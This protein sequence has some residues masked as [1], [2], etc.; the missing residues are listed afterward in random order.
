[1][2]FGRFGLF[3][4]CMANW[5]CLGLIGF[6][7]T[8]VFWWG[9]KTQGALS[10]DA[11]VIISGRVVRAPPSGMVSVAACKDVGMDVTSAE[12]QT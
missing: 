2:S 11:G 1:M 9:L 6:L 4:K 3:E 12:Q 8:L 10:H 5:A 7:S